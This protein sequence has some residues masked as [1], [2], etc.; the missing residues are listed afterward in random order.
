VDNLPAASIVDTD[1]FVTTQFI[2]FPVGYM[3]NNTPF[4]YNHVNI[5]LEYHTVEDGHRIVGFYVEPM[6]IKHTFNAPWSGKGSPPSLTTCANSRHVQYENI[7][8][9]QKVAYL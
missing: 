7:K 1:Q 4:I 6:S 5:I 3:D 9:H 8:D 2:G